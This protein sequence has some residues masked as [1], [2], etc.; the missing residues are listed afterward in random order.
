MCVCVC[1]DFVYVVSEAEIPCVVVFIYEESFE[2]TTE[3]LSKESRTNS[4]TWEVM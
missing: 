2:P 4:L 1:V 3:I